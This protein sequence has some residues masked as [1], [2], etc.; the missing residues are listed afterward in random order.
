MAGNQ[1]SRKVPEGGSGVQKGEVRRFW[2][3]GVL[4]LLAHGFCTQ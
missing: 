1:S 2:V 3:E 4:L